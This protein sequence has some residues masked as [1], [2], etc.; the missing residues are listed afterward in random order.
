[1][2]LSVKH[3]VFSFSTRFQSRKQSRKTAIPKDSEF[4][5]ASLGQERSAVM[6]NAISVFAD[7]R[8]TFGFVRLCSMEAVPTD[9]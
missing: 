6:F 8:R 7:L 5:V 2:V 9:K 3:P 4:G 1:M